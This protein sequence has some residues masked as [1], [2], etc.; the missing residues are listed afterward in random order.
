MKTKKKAATIVFRHGDVV[1]HE[2]ADVLMEGFMAV[3]AKA[4]SVVLAEGEVTGHAHRISIGTS[5]GMPAAI[6]FANPQVPDF[7]L[8]RVA[9]EVAITHEEHKDVILAPGTYSVSIKRQYDEGD[10]GWSPVA[11]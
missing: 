5:S 2:V 9:R 7:R 8:L 3:P 10:E 6:L 11:D 1:V 4:G